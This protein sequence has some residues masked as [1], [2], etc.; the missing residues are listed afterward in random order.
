MKASESQSIHD[1]L[2]AVLASISQD[3]AVIDMTDERNTIG[4]SYQQYGSTEPF[5]GCSL[6]PEA[7]SYRPQW[8]RIKGP[9]TIV[10]NM[11]QQVKLLKD[12][13]GKT[14]RMNPT[15]STRRKAGWNAFACGID[16]EESRLY[17]QNDLPTIASRFHD[18]FDSPTDTSAVALSPW[19]V[20]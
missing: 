18:W 12:V 11:S 9:S 5:T 16:N 13:V 10:M 1:R 4:V 17:E 8:F 3:G 14:S 20:S 2:S 6:C 15:V 19:I 7:K